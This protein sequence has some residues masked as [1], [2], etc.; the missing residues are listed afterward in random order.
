MTT[1]SGSD[2]D[3]LRT[4]ATS[5]RTADDSLMTIRSRTST[6]VGNADWFG[7]DAEDFRRAWATVLSPSVLNAAEALSVAAQRVD[8]QAATQEKASA[9]SGAAA[10]TASAAGPAAGAAAAAQPAGAK[11]AAGAQQAAAGKQA[12]GAT[13]GLGSL[14]RQYESNGKPQTI[15]TGRGDHGGKSYGAYQF[16]SKMGTLKEFVVW[17]DKVHPGYAQGI[18]DAVPAGKTTQPGAAFDAAWKAQAKADPDGFLAIQ[19]DFIKHSHY[20]VQ[21]ARADARIPGL[22]IE[23]RSAALKQV[24]WSMSV[25]H[26]NATPTIIQN[27]LAG[28]DPGSVSDADLIKRIYEDR[29][30]NGGKK[31]FPSSSAAVRAGVVGRFERESAQAIEM[32]TKER[33]TK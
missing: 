14:S 30:A 21:V 25:Q 31:W 20:D 19:H 16:A 4:L 13:P 1:F 6:S 9:A 11:P 8:D 32:L 26:R 23:G 3:Q 18:V 24:V 12:T 15:S 2:T 27:A 10:A 28:R 33:A 17:L 29:G 7:A 5:M 22:N